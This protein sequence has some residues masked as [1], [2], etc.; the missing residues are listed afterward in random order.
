MNNKGQTEIVGLVVIV[1]IFVV[2]GGIFLVFSAKKTTNT[3][4][5]ESAQ[6]SKFIVS[7]LKYTPCKESEETIEDIIAGCNLD[8]PAPCGDKK[9]KEFIIETTKPVL[10]EFF[11]SRYIFTITKN[12]ADFV[13]IGNCTGSNTVAEEYSIGGLSQNRAKITVVLCSN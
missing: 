10:N 8:E 1:I 11:G 3:E 6:A 9:C 4:G 13:K 2:I 5:R 12:E 7:L